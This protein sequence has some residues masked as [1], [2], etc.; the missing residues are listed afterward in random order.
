MSLI[1]PEETSELTFALKRAFR[2]STF[3]KDKFRE[4][5]IKEE[6]ISNELNFYNLPLIDKKKIIKDQIDYP[7]YGSILSCKESEILRVHKTSGTSTAPFLIFLTQNDIKDTI[8]AATKTFKL[9]GLSNIDRIVHCLNFNMWSGGVTDYLSLENVGAVSVPFGS[10]NTAS[11]IDM[12]IKLKINSISCTP[13]YMF[14][15]KEKCEEMKIN[16]KELG[17]KKGFFGGENL[18][19]V[20]NIRKRI[21][22]DF[23]INA[24]DANYGMSEVLSIIGGEDENKDGLIY[25]AHGILYAELLDQNLKPMEIKKGA[26]GEFVFS[27]LRRE[28]QPLFRYRTNDIV[29]ILDAYYDE[30]DL[31]RMKFK[32]IGRSDE[33]FNVKG[34]NFFPESISSILNEISPELSLK[35]KVKKLSFSENKNVEFVPNIYIE[36][37]LKLTDNSEYLNLENKIKQLIKQKINVS[38]NIQWVENE[39]FSKQGL[40]KINFT[41]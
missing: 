20:S 2:N 41:F 35:Y 8:L 34:V 28:A 39:Y 14:K 16:P 38:V 17:L 6:D 13:S 23:N 33:M 32:V 40:N 5:G 24:I 9:A 27:S 4:A 15:I 36:K 18:L 11:L 1:K 7:P 30:D 12:I 3:W 19:Q 22:E 37:A 21:E 29:E 10:G 26:I 25:N 31:I